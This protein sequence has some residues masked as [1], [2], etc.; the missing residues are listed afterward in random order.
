MYIY[1]Y[2]IY[3][4]SISSL[5]LDISISIYSRGL[6]TNYPGVWV[7]ITTP[8]GVWISSPRG[9]VYQVPRGLGTSSQGV[10]MHKHIHTYTYAQTCKSFTYIYVY[11]YMYKYERVCI[12]L[13]VCVCICICIY[14]CICTCI[15]ICIYIYPH[16]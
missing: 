14:I 2:I 9:S 11:I 1:I 7:P 3:R 10:H 4:S 5:H 13:R 6:G 8:Q 12:C 15:I 16:V